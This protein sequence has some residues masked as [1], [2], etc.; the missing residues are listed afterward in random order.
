MAH[1]PFSPRV[2]LGRTGLEVGRL[3]LG[4]TYRIPADAVEWAFERGSSYL[5][6][7]TFRRDE[8]ARALRNLK[9]QRDR[10]VLA[11]QSYAPAPALVVWS[12]E[13]ALVKIGYEHADVVLLGMWNRPVSPGVLDACRGLKQR[14]LVRHIAVSTHKRALAPELARMEEIGILHVRYNAVHPKAE[15]EIFAHLPSE[16]G[17][18]VV[19]FTATCWRKLLDPRRIPAGERVPTAGDCYRFVLSHPSVDVCMTG[20]SSMDHA[21]H[22]FEALDKGPMSDDEM[23]WMRRVGRAIYGK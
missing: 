1:T 4:A 19:A 10:L 17:P 11:I 23:A 13:R 21:R 15:T 20:L 18:G 3:G 8:F 7:G 14:G 16:G 6:W 2:T 22:A 5:Y 9:R 12:F